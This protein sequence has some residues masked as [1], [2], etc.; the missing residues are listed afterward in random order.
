MLRMKALSPKHDGRRYR[1][2]W[3]PIAGIALALLGGACARRSPPDI[4]LACQVD[5]E[6]RRLAGLIAWPS[7]APENLSLAIYDGDATWLF[8]FPQDL[9]DF[10][11][12]PEC[13]QA[14][15]M[16]GQHPDVRANSSIEWNGVAVATVLLGTADADSIT[17]VAATALHEAFHVHERAHHPQWAADEGTLFAYPAADESLLALAKFEFE[18]LR[19]AVRAPDQA[20]SARWA[21]SAVTTRAERALRMPATAI[22]YERAIEFYEGLAQYVEHRAFETAR[23]H[24]AGSRAR[25]KDEFAADGVRQRCYATGEAWALLLDRHDPDWQRELA[26]NDTLPLDLRVAR[27]D[28]VQAAVAS[29]LDIAT[30][31]RLASDARHTVASLREARID[32]GRRFLALEGHTLVLESASGPWWPE[33]FDPLNVRVLNDGVVLHT[34]WLRLSN[35]VDRIEVLD[36]AVLTEPAG[37]HPLFD[38]V[39]RLV[40]AG[41]ERAPELVAG[42]SLLIVR[43]AGVEATLVRAVA[44]TSGRTTVIRAG[45]P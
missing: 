15:R 23:G 17:A 27:T 5:A 35:G 41:L 7:F 24:A 39:R 44:A 43:A 3:L 1:G 2:R 38:G 13:A 34:R 4:A 30:R 8:A 32:E 20:E 21:R 12:A 40:I 16:P 25:L 28:A 18:A 37:A 9:A 36:R 6:F 33:R 29:P 31:I 22:A 19:R 45:G 10:T 14:R 42:D 11:R 26:A